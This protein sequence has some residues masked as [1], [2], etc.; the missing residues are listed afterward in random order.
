MVKKIKP[1]YMGAD[2][3]TDHVETDYINKNIAEEVETKFDTS[4]YELNKPVLKRK[5]KKVIDLVW[6]GMQIRLY[7]SSSM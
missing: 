7:V 5:N 3:F 6:S 2:S 4:N 1:C